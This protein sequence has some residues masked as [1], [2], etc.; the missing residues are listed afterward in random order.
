M[1][2]PVDF[3]SPRREMNAVTKDGLMAV[4]NAAKEDGDCLKMTYGSESKLETGF[5][6]KV[7]LTDGAF[8]IDEPETMPGGTNQGPNP[9]DVFCGSFGTCQEI[10]YKMYATVMGI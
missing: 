10:T 8:T 2:G 4:I 6:S 5:A 7:T 9:L 3:D 1:G